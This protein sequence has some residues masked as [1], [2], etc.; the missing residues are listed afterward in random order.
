[1]ALSHDLKTTMSA[2]LATYGVFGREQKDCIEQ[3][4]K[5]YWVE[6]RRRWES[7]DKADK[8]IIGVEENLPDDI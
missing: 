6:E 4:D 7:T 8:S 1:M 2:I 3:L 5:A